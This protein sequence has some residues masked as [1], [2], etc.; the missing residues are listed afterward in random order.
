[1]ETIVEL[2]ARELDRE[3]TQ[4]KN[5]IKLLDEGNTI[6]FIA[7]YRKEAHGGMDDAAL[8]T[9]EDRLR[10]LHN[11]ER[12]REKVKRAIED[13]GKLTPALAAA[14]DGAQT[15]A[16]VLDLYR[17]Y[18]QKHRTLAT[19]AREKG[20]APLAS[21]LFAQ[22]GDCPPPQVAAAEYLDPD[23]GIATVEDALQGAAALV[24]E[25]IN[26]HAAVRKALRELWQE[27]GKLVVRPAKKKVED[28]PY[29][30]Y[31][32]FQAAVARV[33]GHRILAINRG[34]REGILRVSVEMDRAAALDQICQVV[35]K[36]GAPSEDFVR[37]A[38]EDAYDRLIAPSVEREIRGI[39]TD[40]ANERAIRAFAL[41]LRPLLLQPPVKGRVTMGLDPGYRSGCKVAVVDGTGKVLETAVVYPAIYGR[42]KLEAIQ[43]LAY[44]IRR[45]KVEHLAIGNG[46]A[47]RE[48]ERAVAE[49]IR[50]T[51]SRV[52]YMVVDKSGATVYAESPLAAEEFPDYDVSLRSAVSIA[53][54]LQ[55]PLAELVKIDPKSIGVGQY[56]HDIPQARLGET[57]DGVVEDC[58]NAVGA[59]LNTASAALLSRI[60]GL[61]SAVAKSI[62]KYREERGPFPNRKQLLKVPKMGPRT[63]EQCAGFLRVPE[64]KNVLD[65]TGVHPESYQAAKSLLALTGYTLED[66]KQG[67]LQGLKD[68]VKDLG[69]E[70]T[71]RS[72]GVG[73]PTLWDIVEDLSKPGRDPRDELPQ[74]LFRTDIME[75][76]DLYPGME[77][78]GTVRNVT[79]FGVF[80]DI[81]IPMPGLLPVSR[82]RGRRDRHP[83]QMFSVG[84]VITVWVVDVEPEKKRISLTTW[85][86]RGR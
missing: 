40:R 33:P 49:L 75:I 14:I 18:K 16:E 34:E 21:L 70:E 1:M 44:M 60:A 9:V 76:K 6:P 46:N 15:L 38:A 58:V 29:R 7:R 31:Y 50:T 13:Q 25:E 80:V 55:D 73:V 35:L 64:S 84:D 39:L 23:K 85:R 77:I 3:E 11:L 61:N 45:Y 42:S 43:L 48:T 24:A 54:R 26:D 28:S 86:P 41:N 72:C 67:R 71:A 57:L 59:D 19:V 36:P 4:I 83:S 69:A 78:R 74:P 68:R 62:V 53:R 79:D 30:G 82:M 52:T 65:N 56:Q 63:Y 5:V 81:G 37:Q 66:V 2:L 8:R 20:L 22:E 12:R 17:P 32:H 27:K 51:G 47:S 10:R